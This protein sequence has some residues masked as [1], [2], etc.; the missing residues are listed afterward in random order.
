MKWLA[1]VHVCRGQ[2]GV[3]KSRVVTL[4]TQEWMQQGYWNPG[5][6][7]MV[8]VSSQILASLTSKE[9]TAYAKAGAVAEEILVAI[10]TVTAFNG[11]H[12]ALEKSEKCSTLHSHKQ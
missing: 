6:T 2:G 7:V 9:L 5:V 8:T 4:H 11:Q 10:R 12:R 3:S 1:L